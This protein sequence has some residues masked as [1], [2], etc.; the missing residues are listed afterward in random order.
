MENTLISIVI[1]VYN[2]VQMIGK[3]LESAINQT[4]KNIEIIIVDNCSTDGTWEL[5]NCYSKNESRLRIFQNEENIGPVRNWEKGFCEA[6][7]EFLKILWSDDWMDKNFISDAIALFTDDTAFVLSDYSI[8]TDE[9]EIRLQTAF[10]PEY[11]TK[12]YLYNIIINNTENFPLS[13]GCALFRTKDVI[14]NFYVKSIP[15]KNNLDSLRNGAGNDLLIF[16]QIAN[17]YSI[18]KSTGNTSNFFREHETSFSAAKDIPLH[19]EWA[20]LLFLKQNKKYQRLNN[21]LKIQ[22]FNKKIS[23]KAYNQIYHSISFDIRSIIDIIHIFIF[24]FDRF[25]TRVKKAS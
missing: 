5:L 24:I 15:N 20:K 18:I 25:Y 21:F 12:D 17:N 10:K 23:N 13:P 7:G 1:P 16:M 14:D 2:R 22:L 9:K 8:V 11:S 19:Y 3:A 4:Y 6:K